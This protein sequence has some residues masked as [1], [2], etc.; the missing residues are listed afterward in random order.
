MSESCH[1]FLNQEGSQCCHNLRTSAVQEFMSEDN[2]SYSLVIDT[3]TTGLPPRFAIPSASEIWECCRLVQIAW[4][5]YDKN[6]C[7]I[8]S[9]CYIIK[10]DGFHIPVSSTRIHGISHTHAE[11]H[12]VTLSFIWSRLYEILPR[13]K[14]LV[15]HNMAFDDRVVQSE[16]YR[17]S[18]ELSNI[19]IAEW[20]RKEKVCTMMTAHKPGQKWAKLTELYETYFGTSPSGKMHRA[21]ADVRACADIFHYQCGLKKD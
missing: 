18:D 8:S 20:N 7:H 11:E 10:P 19:I 12:G 17:S 3:E 6:G 9:E 21:D 1:T 15:A 2:A 13:V 14:K 5:L 4:E 16:M